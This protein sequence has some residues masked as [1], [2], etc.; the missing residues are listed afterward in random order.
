[1]MLNGE[2]VDRDQDNDGLDPPSGDEQEADAD[3]TAQLR[4]SDYSMTANAVRAG[5]KRKRDKMAMDMF[6]DYQEELRKRGRTVATAPPARESTRR[7]VQ[8]DRAG[9][10]VECLRRL[11]LLRNQILCNSRRTG[12]IPK[13]H[14]PAKPPLSLRP[15]RHRTSPSSAENKFA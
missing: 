4:D 11:E 12:S 5:N 9:P 6:R 14:H 7:R 8:T 2:A 13:H 3:V 1:M 15:I 10:G